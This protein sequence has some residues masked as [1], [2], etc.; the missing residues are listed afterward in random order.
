MYAVIMAGGSGTRLWPMS[1]KNFPKQLQ[2]LVSEKSLLQE[3]YE[4]LK[5]FLPT[6]NIYVSTSEQYLHETRRHLPEL[7]EKNFIVEPAARNTGPAIAL[8]AAFFVKKDPKA[9]VATIAS[10]HVVTKLDEYRD[11]IIAAGKTIAKYPDHVMT[12]GLNPTEP[13]T[14]LGYIKMDTILDTVNDRKVFTVQKFVEKPKLATAERYVASWQYL[15]NASY[16]IWRAGTMLKL[17]HTLAP[18]YRTPLKKIQATIDK[19]DFRNLLTKEY[20]KFPSEPIDTAIMEKAKKV[21]VIPADLGWS[22]IGSWASLHDILSTSTGSHIIT[23][24]HH[25]GIDNQNCLIYAHDKM[26]ATLGLDNV[27][28]VDTPDVIL[29]CNKQRAQDIKAIIDKLKEEG[30]HLYL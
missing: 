12:I 2:K 23:K 8:I 5:T 11:V 7:A 1:R 4:R 25:V 10:D 16:F 20:E 18:K 30:K 21:L 29:I 3:T 13:N 19:P 26:V 14:G 17:F 6:K 9:I 24:G 28:I 15:W 27:I 22:D